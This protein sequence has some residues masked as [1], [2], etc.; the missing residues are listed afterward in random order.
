MNA[1]A[2]SGVTSP[3]EN[4]PD[5]FQ[6]LSYFDPLRY[7]VTIVRGVTLKNAPWAALWP[8]VLAVVAF[9]IA[10]FSFSAWRLRKQ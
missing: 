4:M 2:L 6:K 3:L 8:N 9:A 7:M 1:T 5:F 10:L